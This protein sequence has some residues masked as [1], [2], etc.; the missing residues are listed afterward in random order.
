MTLAQHVVAI[1][2]TMPSLII[3]MACRLM[4]ISATATIL[5]PVATATIPIITTAEDLFVMRIS[6]FG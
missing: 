5:T 4:T 3:V 1:N 6:A 2:H